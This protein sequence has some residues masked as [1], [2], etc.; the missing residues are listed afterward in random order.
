MGGHPHRVA[1]HHIAGV[2]QDWHPGEH[3][4]VPAQSP[5]D[6]VA[7]TVQCRWNWQWGLFVAVGWVPVTHRFEAMANTTK[8]DFIAG[9]NIE[10]NR[11]TVHARHITR[12]SGPRP[13][14]MS[15][16]TQKGRDDHD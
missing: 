11:S 12:L 14:L 9:M 10:W 3:L 5:K 7:L 4:S 13:F 16:T 6:R 8:G 15:P 2:A 1:C